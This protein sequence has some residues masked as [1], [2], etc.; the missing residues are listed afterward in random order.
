MITRPARRHLLR[1]AS[2][3]RPKSPLMAFNGAAS[4]FAAGSSTSLAKEE[5]GTHQPCGS[6]SEADRRRK[7]KCT[8]TLTE[9]RYIGDFLDRHSCRSLS[10]PNHI[11]KE[12]GKQDNDQERRLNLLSFDLKHDPLSLNIDLLLSRLCQTWRHSIRLLSALYSYN[13][14]EPLHSLVL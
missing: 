12:Q 8:T 3:Y 4:L 10:M 6:V 11:R 13:R 5:R 9:G 2:G 14:S 7:T 1:T